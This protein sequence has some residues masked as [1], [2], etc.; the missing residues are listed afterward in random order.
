MLLSKARHNTTTYYC[1]NHGL[2][3]PRFASPVSGVYEVS[4]KI[5]SCCM[6]MMTKMQHHH[7]LLLTPRTTNCGP[8]R[9]TTTFNTIVSLRWWW[10]VT[11]WI[12]VTI[13]IMTSTSRMIFGPHPCKPWNACTKIPS[14]VAVDNTY[15]DPTTIS[16]MIF[17][18]TTPP[19]TLLLLFLR[20]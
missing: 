14:S 18:C 4:R 7:L 19:P 12:V 13:M 20:L 3:L 1:Y 10:A 15:Y 8:S 9:T 6:P 2:V 11:A 5:G 16:I 17:T